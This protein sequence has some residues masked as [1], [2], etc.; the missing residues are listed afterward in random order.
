MIPNSW[1]TYVTYGLYIVVPALVVVY[2]I[3]RVRPYIWL[4]LGGVILMMVISFADVS[5]GA[6]YAKK[7][8]KVTDGDLP[9]FRKRGW[10]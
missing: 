9:E 6:A 3:T 10:I 5:R 2:L 8:I 7:R 4:S 1:L